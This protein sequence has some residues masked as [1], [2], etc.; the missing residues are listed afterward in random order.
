MQH[1][2]FSPTSSDVFL[3]GY[4]GALR[5]V[6][7][8]TNFHVGFCSVSSF[9]HWIDHKQTRTKMVIFSMQIT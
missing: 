1:E 6:A 5:F 2:R 3:G 8:L 4:S 7:L 9:F